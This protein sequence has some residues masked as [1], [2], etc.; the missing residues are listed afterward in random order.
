MSG[1]SASMPAMPEDLIA[2]LFDQYAE[3]FDEHL[4]SSLQ[5]RTPQL[6]MDTLLDVVSVTSGHNAAPPQWQRAADLGCGTGLMGPLLRKHV[7]VLEGADLSTA[8]I[9]KAREKGC[10]DRSDL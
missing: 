3:K 7:I 6:L 10:Y 8:M 1:D 4:V 2:G 9:N 5:Y